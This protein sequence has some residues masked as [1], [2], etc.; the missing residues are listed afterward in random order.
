[1]KEIDSIPTMSY[2]V[3]LANIE[4]LEFLNNNNIEDTEVAKGVWEYYMGSNT[5]INPQ[6]YLVSSGGNE[7]TIRTT[8]GCYKDQEYLK[9]ENIEPSGRSVSVYNQNIVEDIIG[10]D[11]WNGDKISV[12]YDEGEIYIDETDY[13]TGKPYSYLLS[14]E[15]QNAFLSDN[16]TTENAPLRSELLKTAGHFET[17]RRPT[18]ASAGGVIVAD[19]GEEIV[20]II[21]RRSD[22]TDVNDGLMSMFPNGSVEVE[23]IGSSIFKETVE[24]EFNEEIFSESSKGEVYE[25]KHVNKTLVDIG[26]NLRDGGFSVG[27]ILSLESSMSYELLNN[28][29]DAN[30]EISELIEI[31]VTDYSMVTDKL[32]LD[33]MSGATISTICKSLIYIDESDSYPDLPYNI[34]LQRNNTN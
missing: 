19:N 7:K 6:N 31:P 10:D 1:M 3:E 8:M 29:S 2:L 25:N 24:R 15:I 16:I 34:K 28:L 22:E 27:Y 26:W 17:P 32:Q 30:D 20:F 18:T 21:G 23:D 11:S 33:K 12:N 4:D 13:Y 9:I 5:S 14:M